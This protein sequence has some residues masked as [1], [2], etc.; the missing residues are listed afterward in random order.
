MK[1]NIDKLNNKLDK[2]FKAQSEANEF[3]R[4]IGF[5]LKQIVFT[6]NKNNRNTKTKIQYW[7]ENNNLPILNR[8]KYN[9]NVSDILKRLK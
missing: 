9:I 4:K 5:P 3:S 7:K 6:A 8:S 2:L 1:S